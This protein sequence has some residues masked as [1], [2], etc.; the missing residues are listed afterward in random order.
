MQDNQQPTEFYNPGQTNNPYA[1]TEQ[2]PV[3]Q[4]NFEQENIISWTASEFIY[5]EKQFIWYLG[6]VA[7]TTVVALL[8][9]LVL[10]RDWYTAIIIIILG[11]IFGFAAARKPRVL[12]Y[13]VDDYGLMVDQKHF[14]YDSFRSFSVVNDNSPIASLVFM[15]SKRISTTITIYVP[16]EHLDEVT[17]LVGMYLPIENHE[18]GLADKFLS[19]IKF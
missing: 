17:G 2:A 18:N 4:N 14:D 19:K 12:D 7:V 1:S 5:H 16:A 10:G 8:G 13:A 9:Y 6:L 3:P 15:P 11:I